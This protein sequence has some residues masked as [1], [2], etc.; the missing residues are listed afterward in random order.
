MRLCA[1]ALI[2]GV[3]IGVVGAAF[4]VALEWADAARPALIA[5]LP[6]IGGLAVAVLGAAGCAALARYLVV[7]F[8]PLAAGSGVQHVEA[9]M[10]GEARPAGLDVIPVKFVGGLLA[11]GSGLA[12]GRE[13]P[14]VQMGAA[15][16]TAIARRFRLDRDEAAVVHA[17]GAGAGLAVAFNAPIGGSVFVFEELTARFTRHL[18]IATLCAGAIAV[19]AMRMG[20]GD[21]PDFFAGIARSQPLGQLPAFL[22]M[23]AALGLVGAFYNELTMGFLS[24]TDRLRGVNSV[25][26]AAAIGAA[27]GLLGWFS[28]ALIG[29]GENWIQGL[30]TGEPS[31]RAIAVFFCVRLFLGP[32]CYAAGTPGG[33]FAPLLAVGAAFGALFAGTLDQIAPWQHVSPVGFAVV[34]MAALFTAIVRAPMTGVILTVEMTGR[35][36]LVLP[37][38]AASLGAVLATELLE[39]VPIYDRLRERMLADPATRSRIAV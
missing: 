28:P 27:V 14:T 38:L 29:G 24:L 22:A 37:M 33:L 11:I 17:A 26:R 9:V 18:V 30:L 8:S 25:L 35:P 39:S 32:L 2:A 16:G 4:R 20:M 21:V 10:R 5:A 12:L 7:R 15:F 6:G 23:G 3:L 19:A 36:D 31:Q 34:G 13:G 1:A